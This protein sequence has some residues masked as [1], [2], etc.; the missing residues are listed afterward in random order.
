MFIELKSSSSSM[1]LGPVIDCHVAHTHTCFSC[2]TSVMVAKII[3]KSMSEVVATFW[4]QSILRVF[5]K[6]SYC[7]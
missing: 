1:K 2:L 5:L 6:M 7:R 4:L 3:A